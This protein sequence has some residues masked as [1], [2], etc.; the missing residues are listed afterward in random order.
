MKRNLITCNCLDKPSKISKLEFNG[1]QIYN[2]ADLLPVDIKELRIYTDK[3][4]TRLYKPNIINKIN[5]QIKE[6]GKLEINFIPKR[7]RNNYI[8]RLRITVIT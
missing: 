7:I 1:V 8:T 6:T 5:K 4:N 2:P 3:G